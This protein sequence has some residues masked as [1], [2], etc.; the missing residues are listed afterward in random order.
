MH[1]MWREAAENGQSICCLADPDALPA[2]THLCRKYPETPVVI[3]HFA[4]I[5]MR[6]PVDQKQLDQLLKLADFKRVA[7]KTSAFY[8]LG[9]KKAP[10][11]DLGPMIRQLRDAFGAERLMWARDCP[12]QVEG[13]HSYRDSIA[14]IRDRLQFL[15]GEER[16]WMLRKT[17][18][19]IF[20]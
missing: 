5:G 6:G 15:S 12:F 4:R 10:Y 17:A 13:G 8:A 9:A 20:L 19:R 3:D 14:L 18:E 7:V 11:M 16:D 2:I 1:A